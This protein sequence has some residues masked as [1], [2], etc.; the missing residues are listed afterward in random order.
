MRI[1]VSTSC[2]YPLETE[3]AFAMVAESSSPC[4]E[5]FF[6][7]HCELKPE[8]VHKLMEIKQSSGIDVVSIHPTMSLCESFMMFSAY[9][10]R[11]Q[12]GL[13]EYRRYGEIAAQLGAKYVVM[14]GGKPNGV[15]DDLQYCERYMQIAEATSQNGAVL[16]QENVVN[17][18]AGNI[19]FL[20][21]MQKQLGDKVNFCMDVKQCIRGG[22]T[23]DD[24][25]D[26]V[27][28]NIRHLHISDNNSE[29]DCMLPCRGNYDFKHLFER[30]KSIGYKGDAVIEVYSQAY[31][32]YEE[33][34][35]A[36][37]CLNNTTFGAADEK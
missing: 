32:E 4:T 16:L 35:T 31:K 22:Y 7:A 5:I 3:K 23:P 15:L 21:M 8:F 12:E 30:M 18:R 29:S 34:F 14:H 25:I 11:L 27:G 19:P 13:D 17:Y 36:L 10:R 26:A 2:F 1:G 9:E 28:K 20:K 24:M 33:M 6:N 37:D